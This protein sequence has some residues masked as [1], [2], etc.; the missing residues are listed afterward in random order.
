VYYSP[1]Y[2]IFKPFYLRI[3]NYV[4][5]LETII[6]HAENCDQV[7]ECKTC[8]KT[9]VPHR[10]GSEKEWLNKFLKDTI[11]N[12][13]IEEAYYDIINFCREIRH[14][15]SHSGKLPTSKYILQDTQFEE[16]G[17]DRSKKE[18]KDNDHALVNIV[19]SVS[20]VTHYLMLHRFYRL[21]QFFPIKSLK[22]AAFG[23]KPK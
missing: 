7:H 16:Y 3:V 5:L 11:K 21:G 4:T 19:L 8:G 13:A 12:D 18:Y 20:E 17:F 23:Q 6:G 10:R 9:G 14:K 15:T 2:F 1:D 22:V